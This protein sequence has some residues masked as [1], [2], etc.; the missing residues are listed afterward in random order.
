[1]KTQILSKSLFVLF[2]TGFITTSAFAY[3][4]RGRNVANNQQGTSMICLEQLP[5]LTTEQS[6]KIT[7][8]NEAHQAEMQALRTERR[9]IAD[10]AEKHAVRAEMDELV[11]NHREDVKA[12]LTDEQIVAYNQLFRN[13]AYG[14]QRMGVAG[15]RGANNLGVR[16]NRGRGQH[17]ATMRGRRRGGN[18]R[19]RGWR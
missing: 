19:G 6:E 8:L 3:N 7:A 9:S 2:V 15:K 14:N 13:N 10:F 18:S 5:Y 16:L 1:M 17:N 12:L 11:K 4:G